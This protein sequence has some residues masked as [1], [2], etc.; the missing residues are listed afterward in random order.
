MQE[1]YGSVEVMHHQ[2]CFFLLLLV[3]NASEPMLTGA[4]PLRIAYALL[5]VLW[6]SVTKISNAACVNGCRCTYAFKRAD[7]GALCSPSSNIVHIPPLSNLLSFISIPCLSLLPLLP[8]AHH[9][10]VPLTTPSQWHQA[11]LILIIPPR[12]PAS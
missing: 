1:R 12:L 8:P 3:T 6:F 7:G 11:R 5:H 4:C 10:P 2:H 9:Q